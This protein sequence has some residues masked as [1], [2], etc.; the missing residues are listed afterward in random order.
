MATLGVPYAM[1]DVDAKGYH[2]T[3]PVATCGQKFYDDGS[4][5]GEVTPEDRTTKG[6]SHAY[7]VH[8]EQ[9]HER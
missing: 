1:A 4:L 7:A 5:P 8:Y 9:E 2:V 3:C 6:A